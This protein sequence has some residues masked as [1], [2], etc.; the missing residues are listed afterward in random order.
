MRKLFIICIIFLLYSITIEIIP[1]FTLA[2]ILRFAETTPEV[3]IGEILR[4]RTFSLKDGIENSLFEKFIIEEFNPAWV[5]Y[6]GGVHLL[7]LKGDRGKRNGKYISILNFDTINRRNYYFPEIE[8]NKNPLASEELLKVN[9]IWDRF[10]NFIVYEQKK[11]DYM[12]VGW[13]QFERMPNFEH[14]GIHDIKIKPGQEK[15]IESFM[16][17]DWNKSV[18]IPGMWGMLL[19]EEQSNEKNNYIWIS[20][21]DP[22][23]M[24]DTYFPE[25]E[26]GSDAWQQSIVP[27]QT[28]FDELNSY[29][30]IAPGKKGMY[31]DY[32]II[33]A[34]E[35]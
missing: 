23:G 28:L 4:I 34:P 8:E 7:V 17:R 18:H 29:F 2:K 32:Q 16:I 26:V 12:V 30:E 6:V 22:G 9:P 20:A 13:D 15:N 11:T 19:R 1:N 35:I 10:R 33:A 27:H 21:F 24:R 3:T 25:P 31:T 5:K 14:I